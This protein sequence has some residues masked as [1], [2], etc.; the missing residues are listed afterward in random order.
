MVVDALAARLL[1]M[2][3]NFLASLPSDL[4]A[5]VSDLDAAPGIVHRIAG[6]AGTFGFPEISEEAGRL[7]E[8]IIAEGTG[9]AAYVTGLSALIAA[10]DRANLK[11]V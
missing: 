5:A 3:V 8:I 11:N 7:E 1:A 10:A 4:A 6:R 2:S 9:G